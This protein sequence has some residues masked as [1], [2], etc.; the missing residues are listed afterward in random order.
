MSSIDSPLKIDIKIVALMRFLLALLLSAGPAIL[1][2]AAEVPCYAPDGVT[3]APN[4]SFVPCNKLGITQQGIH[5]S[6]C[7]LDSDA[8]GAAGR[9]LCAA[10]GLCIN[11]GIVRR[12]YCT[13]PT[14]TSP[15]CVKIC[16]DGQV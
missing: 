1:I 12:E 10:S 8:S 3:V 9:D 2:T 14:W 16:V 4:D 15:A 6:C 11:G 5:S 7:L 13:D